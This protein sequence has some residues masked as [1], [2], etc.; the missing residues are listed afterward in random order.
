MM[1]HCGLRWQP[2]DEGRRQVADGRK[3]RRVAAV[4]VQTPDLSGALASGAVG[5]T[6]R[7]WGSEHADAIADGNLSMSAAVEVMR[8]IAAH[9]CVLRY[10]I[11]CLRVS[12]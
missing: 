11:I 4:Q 5:G 9:L 12:I 8:R 2:V 3:R 7:G 1:G 10:F 6:A